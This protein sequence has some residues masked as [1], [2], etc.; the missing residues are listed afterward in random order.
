MVNPPA[1]PGP[2]RD[3]SFLRHLQPLTLRMEREGVPVQYSSLV[4]D[5]TVGAE[6][7]IGVPMV[8]G[9]EVPMPAGTQLQALSTHADGLRAFTVV[10]QRRRELPSPCLYVSWPSDVRRI[11]RRNHVRVEVR[12]PARV[13]VLEEENRDPPHSAG[14]HA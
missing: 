3:P 4:L 9:H 2:V 13:A 7:V 10:V 12:L 8:G 14:S 5:Y 1:A 6:L 11:Q